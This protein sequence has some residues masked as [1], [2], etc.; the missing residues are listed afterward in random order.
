MQILYV[1]ARILLLAASFFCL[2]SCKESRFFEMP[3][4]HYMEPTMSSGDTFRVHMFAQNDRRGLKRYD[5]VLARDL[6]KLNG[7]YVFRILAVP[8]EKVFFGDQ[9]V[10]ISGTLLRLPNELRYLEDRLKSA[11]VFGNESFEIPSGH[12][13][14]VGDN[15]DKAF[16]SRYFGAVDRDKIVGVVKP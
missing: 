6:P 12:Y 10:F 1:K 3:D 8:R 2:A 9:G 15:L 14:L 4:V 7:D 11:S 16:D 5:L 13:F